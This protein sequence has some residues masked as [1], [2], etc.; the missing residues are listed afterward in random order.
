MRGESCHKCYV[1]KY[2]VQQLPLQIFSLL[3]HTL[4]NDFISRILFVILPDLWSRNG[5]RVPNSC[6]SLIF[7][8]EGEWLVSNSISFLFSLCSKTGHPKQF[9]VACIIKDKMDSY[10]IIRWNYQL[11]L[12]FKRK[13]QMQQD[14]SI[15]QC[16][17]LQKETPG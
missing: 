5:C 2:Q 10:M 17:I 14:D 7:K 13:F 4:Q 8:D 9:Q 6:S 16:R 3:G 12:N 15:L 11:R 1:M